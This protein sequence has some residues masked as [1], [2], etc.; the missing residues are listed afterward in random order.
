MFFSDEKAASVLPTRAP[1]SQTS[2]SVTTRALPVPGRT[3][4]TSSR[5]ASAQKSA[6]EVSAQCGSGPAS[7]TALSASRC[8]TTTDQKPRPSG[9]PCPPTRRVL[10]PACPTS[11]ADASASER[12]ACNSLPSS[13]ARAQS[14]NGFTSGLVPPGNGS[15]AVRQ[16][17]RSLSRSQ[18]TVKSGRRSAEP[19]R[20]R[21]AADDVVQSAHATSSATGQGY[22]INGN[23]NY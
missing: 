9:L 7:A 6:V 3:A 19:P 12:S 23:V 22:I 5:P 10:P 13:K 20:S 21:A 8:R 15:K 14:A 11:R 1:A 18:S 4:R 2:A 17:S 16:P